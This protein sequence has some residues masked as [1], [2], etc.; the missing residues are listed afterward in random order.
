MEYV[1]R[2]LADGLVIPL[3]LAAI[4]GFIAWV[5]NRQKFVVYSRILVAGLTSYLVAKLMSLAYQPSTERPFERMGVNP[6]ASYLD[7]PGFP[8]D[9]ALFVWAV[10][11]AACFA[12][13]ATR[14]WFVVTLG[15]V[16]LAVCLGRILALVHTPLDVVGG[17]AA[18]CVGA[19]WYFE[20]VPTPDTRK[21]PKAAPR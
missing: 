20:K 3:V 12:I 2:L 1:I 4:F 16:A 11:F 7:N 9:H 14:R 21:L 17:L 10:V 18:A 15:C 5:P 8:S 19:L 6:G 13:G